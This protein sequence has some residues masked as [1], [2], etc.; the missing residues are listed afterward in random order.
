MTMKVIIRKLASKHSATA[1]WKTTMSLPFRK[2]SPAWTHGRR[3][4]SKVLASKECIITPSARLH[5]SS[6]PTLRMAGFWPCLGS[7]SCSK[8][9]PTSSIPQCFLTPSVGK[10]ACTP[11]L[12]WIRPITSTCS[13]LTPKL[14]ISSTV[15][16]STLSPSY[17]D[18]NRSKRLN[19]S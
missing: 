5:L 11:K 4:S 13:R 9:L 17:A 15:W 18:L 8:S 3:R 14:L 12:P 7:P 2:S 19:T 6:H 10:A 16:N 1:S